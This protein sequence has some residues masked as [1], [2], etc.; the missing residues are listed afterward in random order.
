M[1]QAD[2]ANESLDDA[3]EIL[4]KAI[5]S[6]HAKRVAAAKPPSSSSAQSNGVSGVEE[7]TKPKPAPL[8]IP[9]SIAEVSVTKVFNS[10]ITGAYI[11]TTEQAEKFIGELK[12]QLESAV[13]QG[14]RVRI[15]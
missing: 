9:K 12:K 1:L 5:E 4:S 8:V 13:Q 10:V 7:V 14:S 15:R 6:E 3:L 11:E 2:T